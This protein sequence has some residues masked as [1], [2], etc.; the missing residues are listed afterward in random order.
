MIGPHLLIAACVLAL[1][2]PLARRGPT[3]APPERAPLVERLAPWLFTALA[4]LLR[5]LLGVWGPLHVNG[6]GPWWIRGAAGNTSLLVGYGPGYEELFSLP[7]THSPIGVDR[8]LFGLNVLLSSAVVPLAYALSRTLNVERRRSLLV[9]ALLAV[10]PIMV[11]VA[12][13]ETYFV[14]IIAL[15]LAATLAF[16]AGSRC[17]EAEDRAAGAILWLAGALLCAQATRIHPVAWLPAMLAPAVVLAFP[18]V[19]APRVWMRAAYAF[20][21]VALT[22]LVTTP[23][24][25]NLRASMAKGNVTPG[26]PNLIAIVLFLIA[27]RRWYPLA[28]RKPLILVAAFHLVLLG[29]TF[30][31]FAPNLVIW[32]SYQRLFL[33]VPLIALVATAQMSRRRVACVAA[34]ALAALAAIAIRGTTTEQEEYAWL[35]AQ[36]QRLPAECEVTSVIRLDRTIVALPDFALASWRPGRQ[37]TIDVQSADDVM[38]VRARASCVYF[39]HDSICATAAGA[40]RC[41]AIESRL[42][43]V[44]VA[45]TSLRSF[46]TRL[47]EPYLTS[48]IVVAIDRVQSD[49]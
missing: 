28:A 14:P 48:P 10:D 11:R 2:V 5:A 47:D 19:S 46:S 29:G 41:A 25:E 34:V 1:G 15:T 7:L 42:S 43:L 6:Q 12:A 37:G 30:V 13:T 3:M 33:T 9:A 22:C 39:V 8:A 44:R 38:A 4:A 26:A 40:Q 31:V 35:R 18:V 20:I 32:L 17:A 49:P 16:A 27:V 21:L 45:E 23:V 24:A 36:F